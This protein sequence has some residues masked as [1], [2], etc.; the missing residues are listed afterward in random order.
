MC[1][2]IPGCLAAHSDSS[3]TPSSVANF[4][5]EFVQTP[6]LQQHRP[7]PC[8]LSP[9]LAPQLPWKDGGPQCSCWHFSLEHV[10]TG[11]QRHRRYFFSGTMDVVKE[12]K[13]TLKRR[14]KDID[15]LKKSVTQSL[16]CDNRTTGHVPTQGAAIHGPP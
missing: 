8:I 14:G 1:R 11:Q 3:K 5:L 15:L 12:A 4:N 10:P 2:V 6:A 7:L 13:K 9:P 16:S